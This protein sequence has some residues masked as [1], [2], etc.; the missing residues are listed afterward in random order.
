MS[1]GLR[2]SHADNE[3]CGTLYTFESYLVTNQII[4]NKF[5]ANYGNLSQ[6]VLLFD[7]KTMRIKEKINKSPMQLPYEIQFKNVNHVH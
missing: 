6:F 7:M 5:Y 3:N 2:D 1:Y 4:Q